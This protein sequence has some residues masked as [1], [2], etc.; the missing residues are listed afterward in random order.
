M[1]GDYLD[2]EL[3][4]LETALDQRQILEDESGTSLND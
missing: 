4:L 2:N 3:E 1:G